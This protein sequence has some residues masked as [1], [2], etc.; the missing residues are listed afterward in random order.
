M[1]KM[2]LILAVL[3]AGAFAAEDPAEN[4][5]EIAPSNTINYNLDRRPDIEPSIG[6]P[7]SSMLEQMPL[8]DRQNAYISLELT[9]PASTENKAS[10]VAIEQKWN[11]GNFGEAISMLQSLENEMGYTNLAIGVNWRVPIETEEVSLWGTDVRIGNRDLI[12][13]VSL[14]VHRE[15]GHLFAILLYQIGNTYYWSVNLSINGGATWSETYTWSAGYELYSVSAAAIENHC[16]VAYQGNTT[17]R[18]RR[19][20]GSD[21]ISEDFNDG[22]ANINVFTAADSVKEVALASNQDQFNNRL[23]YAAMTNGGDLLYS[24]SDTAGVT[25]TDIATNV[26]DADRGLDLS[27]NELFD[28]CYIFCSYIDQTN[29]CKVDGKQSPGDWRNYHTSNAGSIASYTSVGAYNDTIFCVSEFAGNP[30]N[31]C[32]YYISYNGGYVWSYGSLQDTTDQPFETPDVAM[33]EGMGISAVYRYYTPTRQLRYNH[34]TYSYMPWPSPIA[35]ADNEPYYNKPALEY[36]GGG[37][38]GVVYLSWDSPAIRGAY[39]DKSTSVGIEE[40]E[41]VPVDCMLM[42]NYPNPFNAHTNLQYYLPQ[43]Q[44]VK[45]EIYDLMGRLVE[46]L[47]NDMQ[48]AGYHNLNWD[49]GKYASGI[50]FAKFTAGEYSAAQKMILIK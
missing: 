35:V 37:M 27:C 50:F 12:F 28:S 44:N 38:Y 29:R 46:T 32:K 19:F 47:V 25:W 41:P 45:L 23:Y 31:Y 43:A 18:L 5:T 14:D 30:N 33:R 15:S 36:I 8:S 17:A 49:G 20:R 40:L 42:P 26:T 9:S 10:A 34:R 3:S 13:V 39:F 6:E 4:L 2:L 48:Q 21:G 11:A 1:K 22:S 7:L 16:Y 24:W